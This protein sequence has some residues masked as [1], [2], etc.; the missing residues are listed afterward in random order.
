MAARWCDQMIA[1]SQPMVEW[2]QREKIAPPDKFVKIYSGI[3]VERFRNE[4]PSPELKSRFGIQPEETVI[5]VVSKLWEGKGHEILID[6]VARVLDSGCRVKLLIVG[7][8]HLEEKLK[9]KVKHLGIENNV[10]F[11]GFWSDVPEIT[12]ILDISVLP[13]FY[14]GMGRVVLEAMAAGK[15]MVACRVGGVPEFV[16]D[17]VTGYLISPGDVD[18]L[19]DRLQTLIGDSDLRQKM[20]QQ[21]AQ[22][23]RHEHSAETMVN[24]IHQ[25]YKRH[26]VVEDATASAHRAV[27]ELAGRSELGRQESKLGVRLR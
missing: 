27:P 7:E 12:A 8:G 23:M 15:P 3:E 17:G 9:E 5:G 16:E 25:V 2:A 14:E 10:V 24:R 13:S 22:R 18:A 6:A 4:T 11:T 20:G 19:V 21:G 26:W 1:I